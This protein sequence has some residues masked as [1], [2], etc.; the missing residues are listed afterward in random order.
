MRTAHLTEAFALAR[1]R[2]LVGRVNARQQVAVFVTANKLLQR[3]DK[4]AAARD[5]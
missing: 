2:F 1:R 4:N 3:Q 5:F